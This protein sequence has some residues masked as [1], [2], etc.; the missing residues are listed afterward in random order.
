MESKKAITKGKFTPVRK[1]LLLT[2][3]SDSLLA[4]LRKPEKSTTLSSAVK[5]AP[6]SQNEQGPLCMKKTWRSPQ[7]SENAQSV[8]EERRMLSPSQQLNEN[9][10]REFRLTASNR[11]EHLSS[12]CYGSIRSRQQQESLGN[13]HETFRSFQHQTVE[14]VGGSSHLGRSYRHVEKPNQ[15]KISY[16]NSQ[17]SGFGCLPDGWLPLTEGNSKSSK[18]KS[19]RH[20]ER[21]DK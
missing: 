20:V 19:P 1:R 21:Q 13:R 10:L 9:S 14:K 7:C 16:L 11:N 6:R 12:A 17:L 4:A 18:S 5:T 2:P 3:S 8:K 15:G